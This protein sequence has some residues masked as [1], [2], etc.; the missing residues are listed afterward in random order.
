MKDKIIW[1]AIQ[2][3]I[4]PNKWQRIEKGIYLIGRRY[5]ILYSVH[6]RQKREAT[7]ILFESEKKT[8]I[9]RVRR[10]LA[11]RKGD[12]A[13]NKFPSLNAEKTTFDELAEDITTFYLD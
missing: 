6:R 10:M 3:N 13:S 5:H 8:N 2:D 1:A 7:D 9:E 11:L 4:A 12:I